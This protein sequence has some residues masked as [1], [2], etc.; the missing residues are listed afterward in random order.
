MS[1]TYNTIAGDTFEAVSRKKYGVSDGPLIRSANPAM[2]E[3]LP[4]GTTLVIP[5]RQSTPKDQTGG[6]AASNPDEV[7]VVVGGAAF[8][9][10]ESVSITR[11]IDQMDTFSLSAPSTKVF[12]PLSFDSIEILIGGAPSFTGTVIDVQ[13]TVTASKLTD[14]VGGY[15]VPGVLN[16]CTP[17]AGNPVE[18][19]DQTLSEIATALLAPFGIRAVFN[20]PAGSAFDTVAIK[21]SE[22]ILFFLS[23]LAAQQGLVIGSS[24]TGDL[25][26]SAPS[27]GT[28]VAR[29]KQG[30]APLTGVV[31]TFN[32]QQYYSDITAIE[33]VIVGL[34]GQAHT[35]KNTTL[36]YVTRPFTFLV[37]D[38]AEGGLKAA[39]E[40]KAAR[41]FGSAVMYTVDV[42][43]WRTESGE[44]WAPGDTVQLESEAAKVFKPFDFIIRAVT[45][46]ASPKFRTASLDLV[47][48]GVFSSK[49]P[50]RMPWDG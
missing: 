28:P 22:K 33:P 4:T 8:R 49:I 43:T 23:G 19:N 24:P 6:A 37:N 1:T 11:S 30:S 42:S 32:P 20:S 39:A 35:V 40:S 41:M 12:K 17:P 25:V 36:P 34:G 10:W 14:S 9:F 46:R 27:V 15:S 31:P 5:D 48:P 7:S 18:F 16:D 2:S 3:P 26:F 21:E 29:L 45:F 50:E 38:A 13:P 44:L 47:L